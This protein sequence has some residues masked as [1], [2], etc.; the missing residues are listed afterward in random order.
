MEKLHYTWL[1][2]MVI[3]KPQGFFSL[4]ELQPKAKQMYIFSSFK[5]LRISFD[6]FIFHICRMECLSEQKTTQPLKIR[7]NTMLTAMPK[8]MLVDFSYWF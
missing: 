7:L 4:M 6:L 8:R 2:K 5:L 1:L 3:T